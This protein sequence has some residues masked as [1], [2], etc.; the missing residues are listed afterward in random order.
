MKFGIKEIDWKQVGA[1]LAEENDKEQA[2]FFK[3]FVKECLTWGTRYQIEMQLIEIS[4][5]LT[6][7]EKQILS[8]ISDEEN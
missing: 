3:S 5:K 1:Q 7:E 8:I 4:N 2:D 6:S